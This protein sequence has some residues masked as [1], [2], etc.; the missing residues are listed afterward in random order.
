MLEKNLCKTHAASH[1]HYKN[2][3][4]PNENMSTVKNTS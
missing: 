1:K 4:K 3:Y 2:I